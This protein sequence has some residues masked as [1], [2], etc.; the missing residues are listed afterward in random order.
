MPSMPWWVLVL[1]II[2]M[3]LDGTTHLIND[4]LRLDFRQTNEW[5]VMLTGGIFPAD[6]YAEDAFGSLNSWLR[7]ITG[8]LFGF[9]IVGFLWPLM[10]NEFSPYKRL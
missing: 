6:F 8:I 4:A 9:G 7:L 3:A 5:A 10:E 1:F 2:P